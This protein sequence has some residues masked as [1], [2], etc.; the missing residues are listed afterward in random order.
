MEYHRLSRYDIRRPRHLYM[1]DVTWKNK[2]PMVYL[3]PKISEEFFV[4][5]IC[6]YIMPTT[7]INMKIIELKLQHKLNWIC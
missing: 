4:F 5:Y 7:N 3:S 2:Q 1:S 6:I